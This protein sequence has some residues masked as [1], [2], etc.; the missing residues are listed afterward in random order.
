MTDNLTPSGWRDV[1]SMPTG[2]RR[3]PPAPPVVDAPQAVAVM[4]DTVGSRHRPPVDPTPAPVHRPRHAAPSAEKNPRRVKTPKPPK[5]V[6]A[7]KAPKSR[8]PQPAATVDK[9][10][11]LLVP[12]KETRRSHRF[13]VA[14]VV[15]SLVMI[16]ALGGGYAALSASR[17]PTKSGPT[18]TAIASDYYLDINSHNFAGL[19]R[20]ACSPSNVSAAGPSALSRASHAIQAPSGFVDGTTTATSSGS[21]VAQ[22][23]TGATTTVD[24]SVVMQKLPGTWC[25]ASVLPSTGGPGST[26]VPVPPMFTGKTQDGSTA[27]GG[28]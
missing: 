6:K 28:S 9:P 2:H 16:A 23:G 20:I 14:A 18:A 15:G 24:F 1:E 12:A 3:R 7:P 11:L 27:G 8:E 10:V 22:I 21:L 19:T 5:A 17:N 13:S 26:L 4:P 25:I